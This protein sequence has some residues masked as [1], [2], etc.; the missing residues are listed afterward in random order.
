MGGI[1]LAAMI[2]AFLLLPASIVAYRVATAPPEQPHDAA[3]FHYCAPLFQADPGLFQS[4]LILVLL[5][6]TG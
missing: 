4:R 1:I 3:D 2:A 5:L 6:V